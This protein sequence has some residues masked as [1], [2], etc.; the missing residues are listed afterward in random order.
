MLPPVKHVSSILYVLTALPSTP[1]FLF[2]SPC[3]W[4]SPASSAHVGSAPALKWK[5]GQVV[6]LHLRSAWQLGACNYSRLLVFLLLVLILL[7]ALPP[8]VVIHH[9]VS[10]HRV[11]LPLRPTFPSL[12][13]LIWTYRPRY[14]STYHEAV[15]SS[16]LSLVAPPSCPRSTLHLCLEGMVCL[17]VVITF[18]MYAP[19]ESNVTPVPFLTIPGTGPMATWQVTFLSCD[20]LWTRSA[21]SL[22]H[23]P[24]CGRLP[25]CA[26]LA[27]F[28]KIL[29]SCDFGT[30]VLAM[31]L[32]AALLSI[33]IGWNIA[34]HSLPSHTAVH[35][36][37]NHYAFFR[38]F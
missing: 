15:N 33:T 18:S 36:Q 28:L 38:V 21:F 30:H 7:V 6:F 29:L 9:L 10:F 3:A 31:T 20:L 25:S 2:L 27:W 8:L 17:S 24:Q 11:Q 35:F 37:L 23:S 4:A 26:V 34:V 5:V 14:M 16:C 13:M 1:P 19:D 32:S 12:S 22:V